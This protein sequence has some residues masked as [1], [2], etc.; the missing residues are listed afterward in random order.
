M[1]SRDERRVFARTT[2]TGETPERVGMQE[3]Q[4]RKQ[5]G[6]AGTLGDRQTSAS[7]DKIVL[8]RKR[9]KKRRGLTGMNEGSVKQEE[10]RDR[11]ERASLYPL[12]ALSEGC[13]V[14]RRTKEAFVCVA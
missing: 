4:T 12:R 9:R 2:L 7:I 3:S 8:Q 13:L 14:Q 10:E 11:N 1:N 6:K 5:K